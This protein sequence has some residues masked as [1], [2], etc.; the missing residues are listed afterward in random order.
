MKKDGP[1]PP[2]SKA[3]LDSQWDDVSAGQGDPMSGSLA[4]DE[5]A[6]AISVQWW[7]L[8]VS[9]AVLTALVAGGWLWH[10]RQIRKQSAMILQQALAAQDQQDWAAAADWLGQYIQ[11]VPEDAERV[12]ELADR[13]RDVA[14]DREAYERALRLYDAYL[15]MRPD[16]PDV[17]VKVA[18]ILLLF[19]PQRAMAQADQLLAADPGHV[20]AMR[21]KAVALDRMYAYDSSNEGG[22]LQRVVDAYRALLTKSPGDVENVQ[23]MA[24][25]CR[26]HADRLA[27]GA[28][29]APSDLE[30]MAD[31]AMD[32]L[33]ATKPR[34]LAGGSPGFNIGWPIGRNRSPVKGQSWT[35]T[36]G[37]PCKWTPTTNKP[38]SPPVFT[39]SS[40]RRA[41][42][43]HWTACN[44][45]EN[46]SSAPLH[47]RLTTLT[48]ICCW[49]VSTRRSAGASKPWT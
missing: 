17:R 29:L 18:K 16:S 10:A 24:S 46:T 13:I 21:I 19:N 35:R 34:D 14:T 33:V 27:D 2:L 7:L 42:W 9:L 39:L 28:G 38:C 25:L 6:G 15:S 31:V 44:W 32:Q 22:K 12:R 40:R 11:Y 30:Q 26:T 3:T 41:T 36:C 8:L 47:N 4:L 43:S 20:D 45:P 23:R 1:A 48:P 49:G 37:L 5:P